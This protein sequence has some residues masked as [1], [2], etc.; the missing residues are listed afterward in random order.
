MK[1]S[2]EKHFWTK[3][4]DRN[5]QITNRNYQIT[6]QNYGICSLVCSN[7][8]VQKLRTAILGLEARTCNFK[9]VFSLE[10]RDF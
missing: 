7:K 2:R 3:I 1:K 4:M 10:L 6:D 8:K 5:Y 9:A